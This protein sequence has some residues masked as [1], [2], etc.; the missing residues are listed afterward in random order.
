M[1]RYFYHSG[2]YAKKIF[3]DWTLTNGLIEIKEDTYNVLNADEGSK[4]HHKPI[5][6]EV[7][8]VLP[9]GLFIKKSLIEVVV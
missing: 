1:Y 5:K 8:S 6:L 3:K 7:G 9:N 4:K 2:Y